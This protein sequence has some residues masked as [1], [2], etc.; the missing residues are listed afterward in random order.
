MNSP[1]TG[2]WRRALMFSLICAWINGW[3]NNRKAGDLRRLRAHYDVTVMTMYHFP[4]SFFEWPYITIFALCIRINVIS[5]LFISPKTPVLFTIRTEFASIRSTFM[6][7]I[8]HFYISWHRCYC[9]LICIRFNMMQ[10]LEC[11]FSVVSGLFQRKAT[12]PDSAHSLYCRYIFVSLWS[13]P[14]RL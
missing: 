6:L 8:Y 11:L 4:Y 14:D 2:Q 12:L 7:Y 13:K 3:V 9:S 1:H 5:M 10:S